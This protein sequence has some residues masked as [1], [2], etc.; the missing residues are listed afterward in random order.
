MKRILKF[1]R[2]ISILAA[3]AL[4][5]GSI[6]FQVSLTQAAGLSA[7]SD[8]MGS[9]KISTASSH[10]IKFTTPSGASTAGATI[11]VTFPSDFNFTS[12]TI[13]SVTFTHGASTGAESTEVLAAAPSATAWG[14]VF[15]GTSQRTFTLTAPTDG[16]GTSALAAN[17]KVIITYDSTNSVNATT[18]G[19]KVITIA[20]TFGDSGSIAIA[21][22]GDNQVAVTASVDPS[23]TFSLSG[24][25]A[26]LGTLSVSAINTS[27]LAAT[28]STNSLSGFSTT[29]QQDHA[30]QIDGT[31]TIPAVTAGVHLGTRE[32]GI[33]TTD[34]AQ[35]ITSDTAANCTT[36]PNPKTAA[37]ITTSAQSIAG[38]TTGPVTE[39]NTFCLAASIDG[40][41]TAG[42]YSQTLTFI[43]TATF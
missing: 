26:N 12:K 15:S 27:A 40:A 20:G 37:P 5:L 35:T 14:A 21:L 22:V 2:K 16:V 31:H 13:G 19:T 17:D 41:T 10:V 33:S 43:S 28:T 42:V 38:A 32:Y 4:M 18:A 36:P 3:A 25:A 29:I 6:V 39:G 30:L 7:L 9:V 23:I 34:S 11:V 1:R 24:N 8:T